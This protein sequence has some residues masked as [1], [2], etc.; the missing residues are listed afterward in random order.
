MI[1]RTKF[2]VFYIE[3]WS[4]ILD[5]KIIAQT[6]LNIVKGEPKAY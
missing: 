2:D 3:N 1:N 6:I 4:F 5:I